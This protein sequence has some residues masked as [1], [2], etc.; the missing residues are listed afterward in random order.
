[1][2][3]DQIQEMTENGYA[4]RRIAKKLA[5][6]ESFV[7]DVVKVNN[8]SLKSEIFADDKIERICELYEGGVSAKS[9][10]LKFSI[11][12]RRIQ[13]W[14]IST[15]RLRSKDESH[16][17]TDLHEHIFDI[18][19]TP[20]KAYWLGFLYAD[21]YNGDTINTLAMS[22]QEQDLGHLKKF[23]DFMGLPHDKII[24]TKTNK[25]Y[26]YYTSKVFSKHV[27]TK[28]TE[29]GCPRAKSFIVKFPEWL[30][31][32]LYNHF[33]RGMFDGDG[34]LT[35]RE[36]QK[37]WKWSLVS[38]D[39]MCESLQLIIL[40]NLNL[41]VNF[42]NISKTG[43]NTCEMESGGNEKILKIMDWLHKDSEREI[44]L[45]RKYEKYLQLIE[46]QNNRAERYKDKE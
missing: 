1:M 14:V 4:V 19:D 34:C 24:F 12:K 8:F 22:L 41:I 30:D 38:T 37:E 26:T 13:K 46:Q 3:E 28:L 18:I 42:H 5:L 33:I 44:R 10:G 25:N 36:K 27:C 29:L 11:D 15:G 39:M 40:E 21:A 43:R 17:F 35:F 23:N 20:E 9:L 6:E 31:N 45:D 2:Y 32:K 16:R 7:R